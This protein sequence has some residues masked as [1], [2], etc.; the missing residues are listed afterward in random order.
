MGLRTESVVDPSNVIAA[1][2][3]RRRKYSTPA[4][5]EVGYAAPYAVYVHE[6]L[7]ARHVTGQA[8][9]LEQPARQHHKEMASI[10][11]RALIRGESL[12]KALSLAGQFLLA[13]SQSLVP[14]L[15]GE[16]KSSGFVRA[17]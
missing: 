16:L 4:K 2:E 14:V 12:E 13:K 6:N 9:F 3:A 5:V 7:A 11:E 10:I 1:L 15:T 8:K 17:V